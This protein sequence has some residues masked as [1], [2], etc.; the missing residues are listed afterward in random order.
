MDGLR[1]WVLPECVEVQRYRVHHISIGC[2]NCASVQ[3]GSGGG[4]VQV[5]SHLLSHLHLGI[6]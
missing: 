1:G 4:P 6:T 3:V 5:S 2:A